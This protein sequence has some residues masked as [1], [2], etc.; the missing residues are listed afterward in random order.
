MSSKP[1]STLKKKERQERHAMEISA[2]HSCHYGSWECSLLP[3]IRSGH[4][5][6]RRGSPARAM[7]HNRV[8]MIGCDAMRGSYSLQENSCNSFFPWD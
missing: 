4:R 2:V 6:V 3:L 7:S 8:N 1:L 5:S